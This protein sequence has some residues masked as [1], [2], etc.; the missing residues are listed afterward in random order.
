MMIEV[1]LKVLSIYNVAVQ[2]RYPA[3]SANAIWLDIKVSART[4]CFFRIVIRGQRS[5]FLSH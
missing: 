2:T 5:N 4:C 3:Q 1:V